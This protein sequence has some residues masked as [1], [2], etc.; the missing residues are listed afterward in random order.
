MPDLDDALWP[1]AVD[2]LKRRGVDYADIRY[3]RGRSERILVRN[4]QVERVVRGEGAG[5]GVRVL[6]DGAWGFSSSCD[7]SADSVRAVLEEAVEIAR[8]SALSVKEPARL[9]DLEPS[10]GSWT[11]PCEKDPFEVGLDGK[12]DLLVRA[13]QEMQSAGEVKQVH[14]SLAVFHTTKGFWSTEGAALTQSF[15]EA[16]G[17][18]EA[19]AVRNGLTQ[20]RSYPNSFGGDH[21]QAGWEYVESLDLAGNARRVGEEA[22]ALL[23]ADDCPEG[24][25]DIILESS[26]LALQVHESC[27]HPTELDRVMGTELSYAGGSFLSLDKQGS[28]RYGSD[29][30]NISADTTVAGGLG[31]FGWDDEGVPACRTPL[32]EGG[33]FRNYLTSRETAA[34]LGERSNG[35]MRADGWNRIPLIRMGN[36]NL[37]PDPD[38]PTLEE[39]LADTEGGLLL[40]TNRSWSID[41]LRL[42]FQF[43]CEVAWEIKGGKKAR[44][45]KS[46]VYNGVTPEFWS[47]CDRICGPGDWRLWGLLNCGKGEPGQTMH[48]AHGTSPARFRGVRVGVA[49]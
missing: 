29:L 41:D 19:I 30:V 35:H 16:G 20:N 11:G 15:H 33:I 34:V 6:L 3:E 47:S 40:E 27:G 38:G 24:E 1:E 37:E 44:M 31:T 42:N 14:G 46:P 4:Q 22:S 25:L 21:R 43:G 13:C 8:A 7:T 2:E 45:F 5:F 23:S 18:I 12:I 32:V 28:L 10:T 39:L 9:A 26:Q 49:K 17:G 36:V 48:V